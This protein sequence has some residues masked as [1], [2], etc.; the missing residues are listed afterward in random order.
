MVP[1]VAYSVDFK[2]LTLWYGIKGCIVVLIM[3]YSSME[4]CIVACIGGI[5]LN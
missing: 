4:G 2:W 1:I 5:F 3:V